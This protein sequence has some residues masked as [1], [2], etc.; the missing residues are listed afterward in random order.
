MV[1]LNGTRTCVITDV[2]LNYY[3]YIIFQYICYQIVGLHSISVTENG[4]TK[5]EIFE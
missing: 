4:I 2:K 5:G 3:I 1:N